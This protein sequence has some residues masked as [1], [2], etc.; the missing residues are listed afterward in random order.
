[1]YGIGLKS[2]KPLASYL[3]NRM[4][5]VKLGN[6]CSSH[7]NLILGVPQGSILG[8]HLFNNFVNNLF[9]NVKKGKL[10]AYANDKQPYFSHR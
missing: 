9:Y 6:I 4:Q 5:C 7:G 10:S 1:M 8:P 3:K 2:L